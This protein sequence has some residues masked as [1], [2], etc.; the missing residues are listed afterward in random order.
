MS[1]ILVNANIWVCEQLPV[2]YPKKQNAR[3]RVCRDEIQCSM[4]LKRGNRKSQAQS[5][6]LTVSKGTN[7]S[8]R[9]YKNN[10]VCRDVIQPNGLVVDILNN[11]LGVSTLSYHAAV[12][13]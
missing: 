5:I 3:R 4:R 7:A 8:H 11:L 1:L 13:K 6:K 9:A 10:G 12:D 2:D